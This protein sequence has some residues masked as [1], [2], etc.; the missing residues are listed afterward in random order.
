M[1][2]GRVWAKC[3]TGAACMVSGK[4]YVGGFSSPL[5][6]EALFVFGLGI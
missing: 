4:G 2:A 3:G 5:F 6:V 1:K